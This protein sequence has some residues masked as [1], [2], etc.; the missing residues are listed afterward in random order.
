MNL[1]IVAGELVSPWIRET[2]A[3]EVEGVDIKDVQD[4]GISGAFWFFIGT[5][6]LVL[7]FNMVFFTKKLEERDRVDHGEA[8]A[9][10]EPSKSL[11]EKLR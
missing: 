4:A 8:D 2:Y 10:Q 6:A 1:G 11:M 3:R 9:A 5:T 7:V